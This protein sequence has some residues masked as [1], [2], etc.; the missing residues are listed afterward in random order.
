MPPPSQ[1]GTIHHPPTQH[2]LAATIQNGSSWPSKTADEKN[3]HP[4]E[5]PDDIFKAFEGLTGDNPPLSGTN[6]QF[7]SFDFD[8]SFDLD[9]RTLGRSDRP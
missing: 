7:N 2:S 1:S 9:L 4:D 5:H 3:G 6:E 8:V